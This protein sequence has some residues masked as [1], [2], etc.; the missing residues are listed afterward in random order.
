LEGPEPPLRVSRKELE[1][2]VAGGTREY[3]VTIAFLGG[4]GRIGRN[5]M[6]LEGPSTR[7]VI[8]CGVLFMP[9]GSENRALLPTIQYLRQSESLSRKRTYYLLTHAHE[10]HIGAIPY[11][12]SVLPG[13]V[14]GSE[15]ALAFLADRV[16]ERGI[17][18]VPLVPANDGDILALEDFFVE[19][20]PVAHSV[21]QAHGLLVYSGAGNFFHTGDFKL[22]ESPV[23][24]RVTDLDRLDQVA[25]AFG[26]DMLFSD[27]TNAEV[28]GA[29]ESESSVAPELHGV[30][31]K[32]RDKRVVVT[33]FASHVHRI[34]Q[35]VAEALEHG[36][37]IAFL[38]RSMHRVYR[39]ASSLGLLQVPSDRLVDP[40]A[41]GE[42]D[43]ARLCVI[44][45]GSQGE[46]LSALWQMAR[47]ESSYMSVSEGD[48]VVVSSS[49]I[50]GNELAVAEVLDGLARRGASLVYPPLY[51][52]HASGHAARAELRRMVEVCRPLRFIP[53][54]GDYRYMVHHREL[55]V[56]AGVKKDNAHVFEDG[57]VIE[58]SAKGVREVG[59]LNYPR[60]F[61]DREG[62]IVAEEGSEQE[63]LSPRAYPGMVP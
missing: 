45:T 13:M 49:V 19:F 51:K 25:E 20:L 59:L 31:D 15:L 22:D 7:L 57:Q 53:V 58:V 55:A 12:Y 41:I 32:H 44:C 2:A 23:D 38:G 3:A 24:G 54:H 62:R 21:P 48:V 9:Q 34:S 16:E 18:G 4:L 11:A 63:A 47:G 40:S 29:S 39:I 8:D 26:I 27:S 1:R 17:E 6:V 10:D 46:E 33:C 30:F 50:P 60:L 35:V 14:V 37:M 42:T 28:E 61:L 5:C 36:R 52:V 43:P 56:E